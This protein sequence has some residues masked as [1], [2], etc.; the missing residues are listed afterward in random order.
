MEM[1]YEHTEKRNT[2]VH[3]SN[4][5]SLVRSRPYFQRFLCTGLNFHCRDRDFEWN[6][7]TF[8]TKKS[9][10]QKMRF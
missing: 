8:T 3:L 5:K 7:T 10:G 6:Y 9:N 2:I 1:N 4:Q